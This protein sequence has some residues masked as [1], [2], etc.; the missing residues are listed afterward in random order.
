MRALWRIGRALLPLYLLLWAGV[1][2]AA[3][4]WLVVRNVRLY[5]EPP[6]DGEKIKTIHKGDWV[7]QLATE[8]SGDYIQVRDGAGDA[9]WVYRPYLTEVP[10]VESTG[11][12]GPIPT[13]TGGPS[14]LGED[15]SA[16][17]NPDCPPEGNPSP[18]GSRYE[19]LKAVN[20]LKN[21]VQG[22]VESTVQHLSLTAFLAPGDDRDRWNTST[23]VE[24]EG[25]VRDV[26]SGGKETCN[27]RTTDSQKYDT[28]IELTTGPNDNGLPMI[29]EVT[30]PWRA[31]RA[32]AGMDWSTS[33]LQSEL[34][35][36]KVR[37]RGWLLFDSEHIGNSENTNP[38]GSNLWRR[39][40]WE[41]HP[42][43]GIEVNRNGA[44]V[45]MTGGQP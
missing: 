14:A 9:G 20:L 18:N 19:Q 17:S 8:L 7:T 24:L 30:P 40:A 32:N 6:L 1:S 15:A 16:Y 33:G 11:G 26:K 35:G 41:I 12:T 21:R 37:M 5:T 27:C 34:E 29:V 3:T 10:E 2:S 22:P 43:T 45:S 28:H 13:G 23:A 39:T 31:L 4:T 25:Y 44:W 42:V 36:H 38:E